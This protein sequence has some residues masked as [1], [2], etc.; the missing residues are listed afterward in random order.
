MI[1]PERIKRTW[2][3]ISLDSIE[4]NY[5]MLGNPECCV[6]KANAY[7][8]GA[9]EL[10]KVFSEKGA[11]YLAVSNIEEAIQL[12][13]SG[14]DAHLL[15]LGYTPPKC[16]IDLDKYHID[17]AVYSF[18][19]GKQLNQECSKSNI[20]IRIHIKIDTG[21]GRI[22]F[23]FYGGHNELGD[24]LNTCRLSNLFPIGIFTHFA[25]SDEG[26]NDYTKQQFASFEKAI[27][28]FETNGVIFQI[29]HCSNS[30]AIIDYPECHLNMVRAGLAL[31]G[32]NPSQ[33]KSLKLRPALS[34]WSI[35]SNVKMVNK[36]DSISYGR[37]FIAPKDMIVATIPIG[38]AD[39][40]W[41][42]NQGH[43]VYLNGRYCNIIGR[44]CM[45]QIMVECESA[46]VGDLVE[47]YGEHIPVEEVAKFNKTIP[48][49]ILCS[50]GERVPR[51]FVKNGQ[52]IEITDNI[53]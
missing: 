20:K 25:C 50:I 14:V 47:I 7:G 40:F 48:Y 17:Q 31:Y 39:G 23:Q 24:A 30:A 29:K 33:N 8:H 21:M 2:A 9:I 10:A 37:T 42:S 22:G 28:F 3:E 4:Y 11:K 53:I 34:L 44:I 12:R 43:H 5:R 26:I 32:I 38:Y 36:G 18:D 13:Q 27:S 52:I 51:V 6:V 15:I 41:R 1:L 16:V 49:E 35:V 45:D 19:Y 46:M